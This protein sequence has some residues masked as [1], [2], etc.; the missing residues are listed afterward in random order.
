MNSR[1]NIAKCIHEEL[2]VA[3]RVLMYNVSNGNITYHLTVL[4]VVD[5]KRILF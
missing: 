5:I 3:E 1:G 2:R 4:P